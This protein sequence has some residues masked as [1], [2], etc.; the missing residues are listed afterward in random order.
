MFGP[1]ALQL[2]LVDVVGERPRDM[3]GL[4]SC[5]CATVPRVISRKRKNDRMSCQNPLT[6]FLTF[7][8]CVLV[9][10]SWSFCLEGFRFLNFGSD[11]LNTF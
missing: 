5:P 6:L 3:C 7:E 10:V 4:P 1:P 9:A 11:I 8:G 2:G